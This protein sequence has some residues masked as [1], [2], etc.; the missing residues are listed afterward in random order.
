MNFDI[1][2]DSPKFTEAQCAKVD[3]KD[4]FFP[5]TKHDEAE[6]LP[7]LQQI[8]GSCIH[9]EECWSTHLTSELFTDFGAGTQ[10][11]NGIVLTAKAGEL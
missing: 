10:P 9:R 7:R 5:D 1:F 4:Y 8:C 2:S 11:I 3:D 6:R